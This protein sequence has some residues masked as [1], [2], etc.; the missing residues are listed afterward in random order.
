MQVD[1]KRHQVDLCVPGSGADGSARQPKEGDVAL[2]QIT[3][4]G[5]AAAHQ[6]EQLPETI[7]RSVCGARALRK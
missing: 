7:T 3:H 4:V 2:G 6:P 1:K 5:G